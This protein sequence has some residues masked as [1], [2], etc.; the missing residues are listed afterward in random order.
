MSAACPR[1]GSTDPAVRLMTRNT[2]WVATPCLHPWH[3]HPTGADD[4][5]T[6]LEAEGDYG[7]PCPHHTIGVEEVCPACVQHADD[8]RAAAARLRELEADRDEWRMVALENAKAWRV[9][10]EIGDALADAARIRQAA[11]DD[12]SNADL[13]AALNRWEQ[14]R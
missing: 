2:L 1:C 8:C 5:A 14:T 7:H 10:G 9:Q 11:D 4:L 12:E 6:R 3:D 13:A